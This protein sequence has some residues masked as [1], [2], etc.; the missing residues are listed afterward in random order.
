MTIE[1]I[2]KQYLEEYQFM[3]KNAGYSQEQEVRAVLRIANEPESDTGIKTQ[4]R[5]AHG[6][7]IPYVSL[8]LDTSKISVICL[9]P[10]N[11]NETN[12]AVTKEYLKSIRLNAEV[13]PSNIPVR[14]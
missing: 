8:K 10:R 11:C 2:I 1:S 3:F 4:Y 9:G 7:I 6:L 14:F 5:T 13:V 12:I